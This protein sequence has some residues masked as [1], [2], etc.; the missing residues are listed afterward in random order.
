MLEADLVGFQTYSFARHFLQT[1]SRI[2]SL[3]TTPS[4]IQMDSHYVSIGIFP[5]GIDI[6]TLNKKRLVNL[7]THSWDSP[8]L[9]KNDL[10]RSAPEVQRSVEMLQEKYAGKKLIV[11]RDKLDYIKGVRQ[12][13]LAFEQ[14][15]IRHP[16][17]REKVKKGQ[18]SRMMINKD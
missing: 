11:A 8:L 4:G 10:Y 3:D 18:E 5:I 12:K 13:L 6:D 1:C 17:W 14:F 16:E 9:T 2:L 7:Y 15:L